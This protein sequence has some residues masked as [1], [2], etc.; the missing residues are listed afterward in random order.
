MTLFAFLDLETTG[1]DPDEDHIL[2]IA[3]LLTDSKLEK[4]TPLRTHVS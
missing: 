1:L 3:W 2:E 4:L